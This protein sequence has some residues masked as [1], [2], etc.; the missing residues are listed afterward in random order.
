MIFIVR[1]VPETLNP[2]WLNDFSAPWFLDIQDVY[3]GNQSIRSGMIY[4]NGITNFSIN[5][6]SNFNQYI[7]FYYKVSTEDY[8][9][10]FRFFIDNE[11][12]LE[13]L[14][15]S[16]QKAINDERYEDAGDINKQIKQLQ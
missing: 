1:F 6:E 4:D 14:K 7:S 3:E 16:L 10:V 12:K 15:I 11:L 8:Y 5:Y 13:E 9:D 2:E